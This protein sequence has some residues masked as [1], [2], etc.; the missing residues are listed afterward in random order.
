MFPGTGPGKVRIPPPPPLRKCPPPPRHPHARTQPPPLPHPPLR[1]REPESELIRQ[2][3]N[4]ELHGAMALHFALYTVFPATI[5]HNTL[6][7]RIS[8]GEIV[9]TSRS[10]KTKSARLP[11]TMV[12][13][14]SRFMARAEFRV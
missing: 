10:S 11:G 7:S 13:M 9:K 14:E 12:P 5:V 3:H 8:S 6:V 4:C 2:R 1:R